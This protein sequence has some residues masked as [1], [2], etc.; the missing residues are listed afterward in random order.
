MLFSSILLQESKE[1]ES[2]KDFL[3]ACNE[4]AHID[5][6]NL[7]DEFEDLKLERNAEK[8]VKLQKKSNFYLKIAVERISFGKRQGIGE[9]NTWK[10]LDVI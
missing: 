9:K 1:L 10:W 7:R 8:R 5:L 2:V 3:L 6:F 4:K